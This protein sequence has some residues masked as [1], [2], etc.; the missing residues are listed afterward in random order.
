MGS[1][2][3]QEKRWEGV[4]LRRGMGEPN[5]EREN[6]LGKKE[7]VQSSE[8]AGKGRKPGILAGEQS[9]GSWRQA[10]G[11]RVSSGEAVG[12]GVE[13]WETAGRATAQT[14][15]GREGCESM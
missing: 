5:M 13:P 9:Q 6:K 14:E 8:M 12:V 7:R 11:A 1:P 10:V 4:S 2:V 3:E 15:G